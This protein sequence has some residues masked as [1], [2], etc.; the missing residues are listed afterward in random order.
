[1]TFSETRPGV[2]DVKRA[3]HELKVATTV[4]QQQLEAEQARHQLEH[5]AKDWDQ[6]RRQ[7]NTV[8]W[9]V[10]IALAAALVLSWVLILV[11]DDQNTRAQ[12]WSIVTLVVGGLLGGVTGYI[13]GKSG[14]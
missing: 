14:K 7:Q 6:R 4:H 2:W 1:L 11:S 8:F 10:T 9:L 3:Q 5:E 13:T 12:A